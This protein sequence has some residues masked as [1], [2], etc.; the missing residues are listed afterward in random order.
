M[1]R[2]MAH[3]K[4]LSAIRFGH[5]E[6][7][8]EHRGDHFVTEAYARFGLAETF[9]TKR[10]TKSTVFRCGIFDCETFRSSIRML[11]LRRNGIE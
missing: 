9:K 7:V 1:T 4:P 8:Y 11:E 3:Y 10:F 6:D 2:E 5:F